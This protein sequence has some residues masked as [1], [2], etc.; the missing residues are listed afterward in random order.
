MKAQSL[1]PFWFLTLTSPWHWHWHSS[2]LPSPHLRGRRQSHNHG[3][4][5]NCGWIKVTFPDTSAKLTLC[6]IFHSFSYQS[7][8]VHFLAQLK[9]RNG[10]LSRKTKRPARSIDRKDFCRRHLGSIWFRKLAENRSLVQGHSDWAASKYYVINKSSLFDPTHLPP[11]G[12][13]SDRKHY[14]VIKSAN[15]WTPPTHLVDDVIFGRRLDRQS[16]QNLIP[17]I[18]IMRTKGKAKDQFSELMAST[19]FLGI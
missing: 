12:S 9:G 2:V 10:R 8:L 13:R 4:S 19:D 6:S 17:S 16:G 5:N 15:F 18:E 1:P 14:G 11:Y 7:N 3:C